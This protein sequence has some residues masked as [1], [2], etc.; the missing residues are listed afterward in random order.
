M[1][2]QVDLST[3]IIE[4]EVLSKKSYFSDRDNH[5]YT[6]YEVQVSRTFKGNIDDKPLVNVISRGGSV[7]FKREVVT[8]N[9][10]LNVGDLGVFMLEHE[11]KELNDFESI[12]ENY[13]VY[14][15][16]QGFYRYDKRKNIVT[17]P[18]YRFSGIQTSFYEELEAITNTNLEIIDIEFPFERQSKSFENNT[19]ISFSPLEIRSGIGEAITILGSD[20]GNEIGTVVFKDADRG[21]FVSRDAFDS[22]VISWSDSEIVI[23]VPSFAGTGTIEIFTDDGNFF[24]SEQVLTVLS[25]ELNAQFEGDFSDINFRAKLFNSDNQGGYTWTY[26]ED[27]VNNI[28]AVESFERAI[29]SWVCTTG[30]S[31]LVNEN[32]TNILG[33][34]QDDF[35]VVSFI[36]SNVDPAQIDPGALAVTTTYYNGC[37]DGNGVNTYVSEVDITFNSNF[38]WFFG[39]DTSQL[40]ED[41]NDFQGTAT[42]ELGHAHN[43]GHV[44]APTNLMHFATAEG[45]ESATRDIDI[46][47]EIGASLNFEFSKI[48]DNCVPRFVTDRACLDDSKIEIEAIASIENPVINDLIV[49]IRD[50]ESLSYSLHVYSLSGREEFFGKIENKNES[51]DLSFLPTGVYIARIVI[52]ADIYTQKLIKL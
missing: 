11:D 35:N 23:N 44:I 37:A 21:G 48:I 30:I 12:Y 8:P 24:E 34:F 42:H 46:D 27:F 2:D 20:F 10:G 1:E 51:V 49:R 36:N 47:S 22:D 4:G 52:D 26:N 33:T 45:I 38:D 18:Y 43:L 13:H 50:L 25:A 5:I 7:G 3:L 17:N 15:N 39:E 29:D 16:L 14:S 28:D 6:V 31:W 40:L 41:Q 32:T 19:I 9:I